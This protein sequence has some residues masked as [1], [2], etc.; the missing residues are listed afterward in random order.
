MECR[1][2]T[3][4]PAGLTQPKNLTDEQRQL[5]EKL[6]DSLERFDGQSAKGARRTEKKKED[7]G[8]FDK[9]KD[10]FTDD[11]EDENN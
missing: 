2:P 9:M 1:L 7:K 10:L 8:F 4:V 3:G 5:F 6:A 11:D